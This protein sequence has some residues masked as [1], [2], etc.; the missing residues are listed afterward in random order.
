M[1]E[2]RKPRTGDLVTLRTHPPKSEMRTIGLVVDESTGHA[3]HSTMALIMSTSG[4]R[5]VLVLWCDSQR[6]QSVPIRYLR[7]VSRFS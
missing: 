5:E 3:W 4:E 6:T 7:V 2:S 1:G